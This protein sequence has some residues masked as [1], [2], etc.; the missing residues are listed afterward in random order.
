MLLRTEAVL[1]YT[2]WSSS[3][4][5]QIWIS[6][7]STMVCSPQSKKT[8]RGNWSMSKR[9]A[10]IIVT[11][12]SWP[13]GFLWTALEARR[14]R[15]TWSRIERCEEDR[16]CCWQ[17]TGETKRSASRF[18]ARPYGVRQP[19][20]PR[21]AVL[22]PSFPNGFLNLVRCSISLHMLIAKTSIWRS[23]VV[24]S[25]TWTMASTCT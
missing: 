17:Y 21:T 3:C 23:W 10:L 12:I 9:T 7:L 19:Y 14:N 15:R 2:A 11:F 24:S 6:H 4:C 16:I 25:N 8:L 5:F 20:W 18:A 1:V 13:V 22:G